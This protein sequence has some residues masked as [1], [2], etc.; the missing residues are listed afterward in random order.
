MPVCWSEATKLMITATVLVQVWP[1]L[2]FSYFHFLLYIIMTPAL[3]YVF[4][5]GK[6]PTYQVHLLQDMNSSYAL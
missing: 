6:R 2:E 3:H 1:A 5:K 4:Y